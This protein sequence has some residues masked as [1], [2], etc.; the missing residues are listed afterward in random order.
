M[1]G[2]YTSSRTL[3]K[4]IVDKIGGRHAQDITRK[5]VL[6]LIMTVVKRGANT[7][8][9][10]VLRELCSAYEFALGLGK[11]DED[12]ANPALLAK[13]S[14]TQAKVKLTSIPGKRVLSKDELTQLVNWL[15]TSAYP[16][17]VK[18][19]LRLTLWTGCRSGEICAVAW[20]DVNLEDG[21]IHLRETKNGIRRYVQLSQQAIEFIQQLPS[22]NTTHLF[23]SQYRRTP[24]VQEYLNVAA[25]I[26][27]KEG[28]MLDIDHWTPHDLRRTVRTGL[29]SLG[30]PN[31]VAEAV[32]GHSPKGIIGV[33]NLHSYDKECKVW[34][35]KWADYLDTLKV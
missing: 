1:K 16:A 22:K 9:G 2:Q 7:Q 28:K 8:A 33:Y 18:N 3:T 23:S 29:A 6:D 19:A 11:L 24:I 10:I 12:F 26:L 27:R 35:Q 32:L 4:D 20:K 17:N 25:G 21:T 34:L 30:C 15:P 5:D 31:E 13:A 14:L